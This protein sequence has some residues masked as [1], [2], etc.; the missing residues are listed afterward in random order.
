MVNE[1]AV[2]IASHNRQLK[3]AEF[4]IYLT[5]NKSD[6]F[7]RAPAALIKE[8]PIVTIIHD[9]FRNSPSKSQFSELIVLYPQ[10]SSMK[11]IKNY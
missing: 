6:C 4:L 3:R 7:P 10:L 5:H 2:Q 9:F 1:F 8:C 11:F